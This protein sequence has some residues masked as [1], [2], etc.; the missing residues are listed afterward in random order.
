MI[1]LEQVLSNLE[2]PELEAKPVRP[3][4]TSLEL[5]DSLELGFYEEKLAETRNY[6]ENVTKTSLNV[7]SGVHMMSHLNW[8]IKKTFANF[9]CSNIQ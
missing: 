3:K 5:I 6:N 1:F 4:P 2:K 9:Y 7:W 8:A